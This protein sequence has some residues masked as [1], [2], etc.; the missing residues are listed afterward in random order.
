MKGT[1]NANLKPEDIT[2][3]VKN[4]VA[5]Y[6]EKRLIAEIIREEVDTVANKLLEQ[7]NFVDRF[8]G[9]RITNHNQLYRSEQEEL[10][11]E[12]WKQLDTLLRQYKV[13][14]QDMGADYCPA[15]VAESEQM[16]AEAELIY[17]MA[18]NF[19]LEIEKGEFN[20][21]LL[22]RP[23]GLEKRQSFIDSAVGLVLEAEKRM[24]KF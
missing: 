6:L 23:K 2:E 4:A 22:C 14:P 12:F 24:R 20:S 9:E 10:I 11:K 15:L 3:E 5:L 17:R 21:G 18:L 8:T 13:K 19:G 7:Y 1:I 16:E